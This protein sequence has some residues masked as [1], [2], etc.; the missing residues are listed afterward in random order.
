MSMSC[1]PPN[2]SDDSRYMRSFASM[3][4]IKSARTIE[5]SSIIMVSIFSRRSWSFSEIDS[6]SINSGLT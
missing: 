4:S 5:T 6:F 1:S 2:G 3:Q